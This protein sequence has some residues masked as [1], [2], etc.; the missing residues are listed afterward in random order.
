M[1][2]FLLA[3]LGLAMLGGCQSQPTEPLEPP[4]TEADKTQAITQ[5]VECVKAAAAILDDHVSDAMTIAD[6]IVSGQCSQDADHLIETYTR[7][8]DWQVKAAVRQEMYNGKLQR[9]A[10]QVVL[11]QRSRRAS[12]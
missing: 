4:A 11:A 3:A 10:A 12:P 8:E 6:A 7:G 5:F 1:K 9:D 2:H